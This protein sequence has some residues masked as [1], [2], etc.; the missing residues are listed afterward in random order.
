MPDVADSVVFIGRRVPP[1]ERT[2]GHGPA[3]RVLQK[4]REVRLLPHY[5]RRLKRKLRPAQ[6]AGLFFRASDDNGTVHTLDSEAAW[7]R[8]VAINRLENITSSGPLRLNCGVGRA[9]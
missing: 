5:H 2:T 1:P 8:N 4:E 9:S 3:R 7:P 6:E